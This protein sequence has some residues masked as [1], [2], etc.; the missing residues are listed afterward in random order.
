[1]TAASEQRK[2]GFTSFRTKLLVAMMLIVS[3]ITALAV[4]LAE[5]NAAANVENALQREFQ[6]D[7]AVL[8]NR[9]EIRHAA[10]VERCRALIRRPRIQ[11][12]LEDGALDLLYP[13]ARDEMRDLMTSA[14]T[15]TSTE[16]G[17]V[18]LR[19]QFYRFLDREGTVIRPP[20]AS[21]VGMLTPHEEAQL[22]LKSPPDRQHIG[23]LARTSP[24]AADSSVTEIIAM[25]ILSNNTGELLAAIIL[26]FEPFE[27]AGARSTRGLKNGIW[28][29]ERLHLPAIPRSARDA[30][31]REITD[32]IGADSTARDRNRFPVSVDGA[33][34]L[35]FYKKLNAG[36][37]FPPAYEV[38]LYPLAPLHARQRLLR[39]QVVGTG[40]LLFVAGLT[41]SQ[42]LSGRL[43]APVEKLA[44]DSVENRIQ[45]ERAE[46]A[47][48]HTSEELQRSARFSADASHQLKTPVTVLRAGLE[49]LMSR[50]NLT[51][52]DCDE[53]STLVHQTYRLASIIED[54]LLLAR[55]DAGR[56]QIDFTPVNLNQL[57]EALLD[58][59][60]ALPNPLNLRVG[61]QVPPS[62]L[63]AGEKR[64]LS[65]ILQNLLENAR[66]YNRADGRIRV[67]VRVE[68]SW[69][70]LIVGNTGRP[71]PR[72]MHE[73]IFER[74]HRG[75]MGENIPGH[76]LGLNL[77]RELVRIHG[78]DL[79]LSRSGEDWTEFEARF[80]LA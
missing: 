30:I 80:R 51:A 46:A 35:L 61:T 73:H 33:P 10:L 39:W 69:A 15:V 58:D 26:G 79:V 34:H 28:L 6:S 5:R 63:I 77:A 36:S 32:A 56:V 60:T 4:Y 1:V 57:I 13:T 45:R 47:L 21:E 66:K 19:A 24:S 29:D 78:G 74:F 53:I 17:P 41:A 55:I 16:P 38:S 14:P 59:H 49:E 3:A 27:F 44:K 20:H 71:I 52:A 48:E 72:E 75:A 37:L 23:Y 7:L 43:S 11:A 62:V 31:A 54:L 70:V 65:L 25:P 22:L 76:G 64:Y 42:F 67:A 12:A 40:V 9:Q 2:A 68:D 50:P 8:H 18:A